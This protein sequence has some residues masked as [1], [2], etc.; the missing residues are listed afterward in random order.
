MQL[1]D[2]NLVKDVA[3]EMYEVVILIPGRVVT[4]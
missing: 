3:F 4:F 1:P 2:I